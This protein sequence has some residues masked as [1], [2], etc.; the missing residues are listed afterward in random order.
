MPGKL[1]S[2]TT[3]SATMGVKLCHSHLGILVT[4]A[5]PI[6]CRKDKKKGIQGDK[7]NGEDTAI[8]QRDQLGF[9]MRRGKEDAAFIFKQRIQ[10]IG[11]QPV[12]G[13]SYA[14]VAQSCVWYA[15]C[16]YVPVHPRNQWENGNYNRFW[17]FPVQPP[18]K[19][20]PYFAPISLLQSSSFHL[21]ELGFVRLQSHDLSP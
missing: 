13:E 6:L 17:T 1:T 19:S 16:E 5:S 3:G 2:K 12:P 10:K 15:E 20:P 8:V 4:V 7:T 18:T 14:L 9:A 21:A 11:R